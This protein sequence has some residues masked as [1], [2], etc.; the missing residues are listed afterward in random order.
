MMRE[1]IRAASAADADAIAALHVASWRS[2]YRGIFNDSTLGPALDEERRR[3]WRARLATM[4]AADTV[5]IADG[6]G[7]IAVGAW[8]IFSR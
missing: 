6:R 3:H 8:T 7:F 1:T 4:T 2:A 5:L